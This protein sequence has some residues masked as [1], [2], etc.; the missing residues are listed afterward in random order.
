VTLVSPDGKQRRTVG[1]RRAY[2]TWS[3]DGKEIYAL[4]RVEGGKWRFGAIDVKSGAERTI[5]EYGPE[6]QFAS[7]YNPSFPMSL[8]P[9]GRNIATTTAN[10]RSDIWLLEGFPHN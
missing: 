2:I 1:N 5:Y 9:D 6:V 4:G 10:V 7:A 3:R 8:S